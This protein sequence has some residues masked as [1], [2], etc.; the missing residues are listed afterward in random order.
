MTDR[1][2]RKKLIIIADDFTGATDTGVQFRKAGLRVNVIISTLHL[3]EDLEQSDVLVVDLE[4]RFDTAEIAY[5]KCYDL[6]KQIAGL[7]DVNIYKKLDSTFRG[8]IGAEIDGLM[9]SLK[10]RMSLVAP[11]WPIN[12]RTTENGD[13]Y[14]NGVKLAKTE[15]ANDP[16]TPVKLSG[17][18][19]IINLQSK[20]K[21]KLIHSPKVQSARF[22]YKNL[23]SDEMGKGSEIL[24][25]DCVREAD[26][27]EIAYL[28][29]HHSDFPILMVG[30]A[31]LASHLPEILF[32]P[33]KSLCFVFS[34]SV[35]EKTERQLQYT[36]KHGDCR[37][38]MMDEVSL[39]KDEFDSGEITSSVSDE[40][41]NGRKWFIFTSS[42]SGDNVKKVFELADKKG[43]SRMDAAEKVAKYIGGLAADLISTFNPSGV[44]LTGGD[45]AIKTV[46][47]LNATGINLAKEI[48]PGIPAGTLTGSTLKSNI[49][50]KSGGFGH[51]DAILK[52]LE[53]FNN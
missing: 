48:L 38:F 9:D 43:I 18:A 42:L 31:G 10:I 50:T 24:I 6:G 3:Q 51:D 7:A 25:F 33:H 34:G 20:R 36:I 28:I 37:L 44:L 23:I 27:D 49:A 2:I 4:S 45:I 17:V 47:A 52:T 15:A 53:S 5:R 13:I 40:I 22:K 32:M 35:S 26:L 21:C 8:N 14:I 29:Q 30:S 41:R 19:G 39:L 12:G 11:A 16:R 46:H 1:E